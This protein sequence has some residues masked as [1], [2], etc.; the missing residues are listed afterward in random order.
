[1][2]LEIVPTNW[3]SWN[4]TV[5]QQSRPI[6]GFDISWWRERGSLTVEGKTY[7]VSREGMMSGDFVLESDRGI[8]ARATKLS[9][10]RRSFTV[11]SGAKTYTL[12]AKQAFR[13]SFVL[14]DGDREIGRIAPE[15]AWG[16]RAS[17]N[18]PADVPLPVQVFLVWL[19]VL[20]WKRDS[21]AAAAS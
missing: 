5:S 12:R 9:A 18:L 19:T 8:L 16:R 11:V 20:L 1:M 4:F 3:F 2:T 10:L 6:A 21:D 17:A 14:L 15:S 7:P 13:R